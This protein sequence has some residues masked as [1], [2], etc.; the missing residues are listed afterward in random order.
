MKNRVWAILYH[1]QSTAENPQHHYCPEGADSW[2]FYQHA[3]ATGQDTTPPPGHDPISADIASKLVAE[4]EQLTDTAKLERCCRNMTQNANEAFNAQIWKRCPKT[5]YVSRFVVKLG[6]A[7]ALLAFNRG[8][9][10]V[11]RMLHELNLPQ[12]RLS[13]EMCQAKTNDV[14]LRP[15]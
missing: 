5:I 2:C 10:G 3:T 12:S 8:A 9:V 6:V 13:I 7:L 14:F 4:F 11:L 15:R 1:S